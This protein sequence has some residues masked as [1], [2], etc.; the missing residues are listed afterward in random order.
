MLAE[1]N[2][3]IKQ[4][5]KAQGYTFILGATESGNIVYAADGTDITSEVL[6]GLNDQYDRQHPATTAK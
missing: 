4:Y 3:Y 2:A 6:K 1:I 5:G